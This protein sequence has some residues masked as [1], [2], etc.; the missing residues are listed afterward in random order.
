ML[1]QFLVCLIEEEVGKQKDILFPFFQV[2]HPQGKFIDTMEKV[3]TE[4]PFLDSLFQILVGGG[5]QTDINRNFLRGTDR[6][7]LSLL[8]GTKK[9]YLYLV[10][11]ITYFIQ[12]D[13]A[14]I[15]GNERSGLVRQCSCK[16]A[17][18]M[19]EKLGCS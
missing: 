12:E 15:G 18:H 4:S 16:R 3:F 1:V 11:E 13:S 8:Q 6:T 10:T 7:N 17:F 9:L 14:S 2:G 19:A 5:Y